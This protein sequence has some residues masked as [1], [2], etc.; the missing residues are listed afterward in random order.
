MTQKIEGQFVPETR[1]LLASKAWS[2]AG[3][4]VR[5]LIDFLKL[6]HLRHAGKENGRL[7][8]PR[9]QLR[10]YKTG[11]RIPARSVSDIIEEAVNLGLIDAHRGSRRRAS[12]YALTWLPL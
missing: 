6:E 11:I 1:E 5:R 4:H 3:I 8:A 12:T 2:A 9:R 7:T 10:D